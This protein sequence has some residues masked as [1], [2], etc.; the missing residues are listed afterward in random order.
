MLESWKDSLIMLV[1]SEI[2]SFMPI[3]LLIVLVIVFLVISVAFWAWFAARQIGFK[4]GS[5]C[6]QLSK[7]VYEYLKRSKV[8]EEKVYEYFDN[9][10]GAESLYVKLVEEFE[11]CIL[12][13]FAFYW[14]HA[15]FMITQ[16][17]KVPLLAQ[18]SAPIFFNCLWKIR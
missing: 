9:E 1:N 7:L 18:K 13:Y 12:A 3:K 6:P 8:W 10:Q 2:H 4:D 11:R 16:V 5:D 14:S 17:L 15:C